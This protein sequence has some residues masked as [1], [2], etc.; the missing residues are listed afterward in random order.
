MS[1][2]V[3]ILNLDRAPIEPARLEQLTRFM[4]FRG[5]DAQAFWIDR[6]IG[7]GH[8]LL[9][10]T[11]E[12]E[13]E[14]QP[15]TLDGQVWITADA[16]VDGRAELIE[17]LRA[18]GRPV[19]NTTN[20]V[21]LILHAYAVWETKC[22]EHLLGDF[23]FAIWDA[24]KQQ[25]FCAR[26]QFGIV[27][28]YYAKLGSTLLFGNTLASLRLYPGISGALN[29]QALGDFLLF[30]MN[31]DARTTTFRAIQR[32]PP[33]HMLVCSRETFSIQKY[34]SLPPEQ[35]EVD[36]RR[37]D[38]YIERF[39]ELFTLAVR[40][41]LRT[42]R[43]SAQMSGGL[44]STS[45][46][47]TAHHLLRSSQRDFDL[48]TFTLVY[49][50]L[51]PDEEGRYAKLVADEIGQS[52]E[53]LVVD[54]Y[55][56]ATPFE[57]PERIAPEPFTI[58][59]PNAGHEL[60]RRAAA[61]SRVLLTGYG[62]DPLLYPSQ[63]YLFELA[64]KGNW[65]RLVHA[66]GENVRLQ[67]KLPPLY[68]RTRMK[69]RHGKSPRAKLPAWLQPSLVSRLG[70][71]ERWNY[72]HHIADT[73]NPREQMTT[74]PFWS[75][76]FSFLDASFIGL[77]LK[78]QFPFFDVRL[79]QYVVTVPPVPWFVNKWLLRAAMRDMIPS[80]V[81][82]RPKTPL[83]GFPA[84]TLAQ[85]W[86]TPRWM[87]ELAS[88]PELSR[89]V[90]PENLAAIFASPRQSDSWEYAQARNPLTLAYWLRH[91]RPAVSIP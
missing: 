41:R 28:F 26:D 18:Q 82:L 21:E 42:S 65:S 43:L 74:N 84:F 70:L 54:E 46:V 8:A 6:H 11:F 4:S 60:F 13:T 35:T 73:V 31:M 59:M 12:S 81:R 75:N 56:D 69:K 27:P 37:A 52:P 49:N 78:A 3:G 51:I 90:V 87:R 68:L 88:A 58:P 38:E 67:G 32:L 48:C 34:W 61:F 15:C 80:P 47:V 50:A 22:L 19:S 55:K 85:Q 30:S 91:Q 53:I 2:I 20:D 9:R 71:A 25:L 24:R 66:L 40:D 76:L 72:V 45:V 29:E 39:R 86:G 79:L 77:P 7:F 83:A 10:T 14:R 36:Y 89:Y 33:A 44:D 62:G 1:G 57:T 17:A 64:Q 16:R 63:T 23:S 5:P